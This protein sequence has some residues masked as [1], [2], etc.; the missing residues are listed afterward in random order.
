M[1]ILNKT[2]FFSFFLIVRSIQDRQVKSVQGQHWLGEISLYNPHTV[3]QWPKSQSRLKKPHTSTQIRPFCWF[4]SKIKLSKRH[5]KAAQADITLVSTMRQNRVDQSSRLAEM[6]LPQRCRTLEGNCWICSFWSYS[7]LINRVQLESGGAGW[8]DHHNPTRDWVTPP[9]C[10]VALWMPGS[11][12]DHSVHCA[13]AAAAHT[14]CLQGALLSHPK[15]RKAVQQ[16]AE[17]EE[18]TCVSLWSVDKV[19]TWVGGGGHVL[20]LSG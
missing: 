3:P 10:C 13:A 2:D 9:Q 8:A 5:S 7:S 11:E 14:T 20:P 4:S 12:M 19:I 18:F 15:L 16:E 1:Q 17:P 6:E